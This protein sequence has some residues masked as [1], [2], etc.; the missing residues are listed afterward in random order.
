[1]STIYSNVLS[2]ISSTIKEVNPAITNF[3]TENAPIVSPT[4][5]FLAITNIIHLFI[6]LS[7]V[8]PVDSPFKKPLVH[9][10]HEFLRKTNGASW[11]IKGLVNM[12]LLVIAALCFYNT[13]DDD[14]AIFQAAIY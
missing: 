4:N 8:T 9:L 2:N 7:I 1:M 5:V 10:H 6:F 14:S 13:T 11:I 12:S 3:M